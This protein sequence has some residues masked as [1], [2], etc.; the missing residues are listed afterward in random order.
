MPPSV[1]YASPTQAVFPGKGDGTLTNLASAN[2]IPHNILNVELLAVLAAGLSAKNSQATE[3]NCT[4]ESWGKHA[5]VTNGV[6]NGRDP[7]RPGAVGDSGMVRMTPHWEI[8]Q[9]TLAS[10]P[11]A[12]SV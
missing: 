6:H 9:L 5:A 12:M 11:L 1:E 7:R 2:Q 8:T 4:S 10:C 3:R